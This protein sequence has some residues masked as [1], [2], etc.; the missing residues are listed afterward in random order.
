M[1]FSSNGKVI[2][3]NINLDVSVKELD[4]STNTWQ[5][6]GQAI[7]V[8]SLTYVELNKD[9]TLLAIGEPYS[10]IRKGR[11][12]VL[13][14]TGTAWEQRG[15]DL[16]GASAQDQFGRAL[17]FSADGNIL[18]VGSQY[19]DVDVT[20]DN[21]DS[22]RVS[23]FEWNGAAW[24]PKGSNIDGELKQHN[25][26]YDVSLSDDGTKLA[27]VSGMTRSSYSVSDPLFNDHLYVY[28]F[29][30]NDW[31]NMKKKKLDLT[32][33]VDISGDGSRFIVGRSERNTAEVFGF[34]A[35][36]NIEQIGMNLNTFLA[37]HAGSELGYSV[38]LNYDGSAAIVGAKK[39]G[40]DDKG[41]VLVLDLDGGSWRKRSEIIGASAG[42]QLGNDVFISDDGFN[43]AFR[44]LHNNKESSIYEWNSSCPDSATECC[45]ADQ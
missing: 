28:S 24:V 9:G 26:G 31:G 25:L 42:D 11:V 27:I 12:R 8:S 6:K 33:K 22:G 16:M 41:A 30:N 40:T 5:P 17:S 29:I 3:V 34:D 32:Q 23:V 18:A 13:H 1:A 37:D 20:D 15:L 19:T 43:I 10:S 36:G 39:A 21:D 7:G 35:N 38:G 14:W 4:A 45:V 2:A 44:A